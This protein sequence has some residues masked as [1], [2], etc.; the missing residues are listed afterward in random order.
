MSQRCRFWVVL[1]LI[2]IPALV[3]LLWA[4]LDDVDKNILILKYSGQYGREDAANSLGP[5]QA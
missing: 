5:I 1:I 3:Y 4:R 2:A